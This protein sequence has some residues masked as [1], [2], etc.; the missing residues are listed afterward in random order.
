MYKRQGFDYGRFLNPVESPDYRDFVGFGIEAEF[1]GPW[2]TLMSLEYGIAV[3][4]DIPSLQWD[5]QI[6][7]TFL[8]LF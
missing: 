1:M 8:K 4:S 7:F 6:L 2:G 5:Q 3:H